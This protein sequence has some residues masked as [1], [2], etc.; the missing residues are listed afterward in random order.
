MNCSFD[1]IKRIL[2]KEDI[3]KYDK[4]IVYYLYSL[5]NNFDK[6]C[7]WLYNLDKKNT[8]NNMNSIEEIIYSIGDRKLTD[9]ERI[10][11]ALD[12]LEKNIKPDKESSKNILETIQLMRQILKNR[13]A[14]PSLINYLKKLIV[15]MQII[16]G[17]DITFYSVAENLFEEKMLKLTRNYR[18]Y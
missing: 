7:S 12:S 4:K 5:L 1:D 8:F 15:E 9:I 11:L 10:S 13:A 17:Q 18:G 14:S 2:S 6:K 16:L 3:D